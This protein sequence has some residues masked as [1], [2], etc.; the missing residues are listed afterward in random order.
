MANDSINIKATLDTSQVDSSLKGMMQEMKSLRAQLGSN[1]LSPEDQKNVLKRMGELRTSI[2]DL[3]KEVNRVGDASNVFG[4]ISTLIMPLAGAF[5]AIGSSLSIFGIE[6]EK[7]NEILQKT[8]Q[9]TI[10]LMA[11]QQVADA[12]KLKSLFLYRVEQ[13]KSFVLS[14]LVFKQTVQQTV[15]DTAGSKAKGLQAIWTGVATKAQWLW[16]AAITANPIGAIVVAIAA[17]VAGIILLVSWLNR[18]NKVIQQ[19]KTAID[20]TKF[21][22]D[23]LL[24]SYNKQAKALRDLDVE[25]KIIIG[26]LGETS[27]ALVRLDNEINDQINTI[28]NEYITKLNELVEKQTGFWN[29]IWV[30]IRG[31]FIGQGNSVLKEIE[32]YGDKASKLN[33]D[34]QNQ[35]NSIVEVGEKK[36]ANIVAKWEADQAKKVEEGNVKQLNYYNDFLRKKLEAFKENVKNIDAILGAA[37]TTKQELEFE[38]S[39]KGLSEAEQQIKR[40]EYEQSKF[41]QEIEKTNTGYLE[42]KKAAEENLK[43]AEEAFKMAEK[44]RESVYK[45]DYTE[46]L[47][48]I[49]IIVNEQEKLVRSK[50]KEIDRIMEAEFQGRKAQAAQY[51]PRIKKLNEDIIAAKKIITDATIQQSEYEN[52]ITE[53]IQKRADA[54]ATE[55]QLALELSNARKELKRVEETSVDSINEQID[56][57]QE[58]TDLQIKE[59][60]NQEDYNKKLKESNN[61]LTKQERELEILSIKANKLRNDNDKKRRLFNEKDLEEQKELEEERLNIQKGALIE[62]YK[63]RMEAAELAGDSGEIPLLKAQLEAGLTELEDAF[64]ERWKSIS[65]EIKEGIL[66]IGQA[67]IDT[68]GTIFANDMINKFNLLNEELDNSVRTASDSL[69]KLR[70]ADLI[71]EQEYNDKKAA[72]AEEEAIKS[73]K[74]RIDQAK[75]EKKLALIQ[76]ALNTA[77]AV[78]KSL[79]TM[80]VPLGIPSAIIAGAMGALQLALVA[81]Q[82]INFEKGGLI[83]GKRHMQ[84]GTVIEAE[85]GEFIVNR[86]AMA[87]PGAEVLLNN[88]NRSALASPPGTTNTT[89]TI[90]SDVIRQIVKEIASIPVINVET[91]YTKTQRKVASIESNSRW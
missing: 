11:L 64:V 10:G 46:Q 40:L 1:L 62:Y 91:D 67:L 29:T 87:Q 5:T 7:V 54:A 13:L 41:E 65:V 61:L 36:R 21:S 32:K 80:G 63:A 89:S 2:G 15:A 37:I 76:I 17:L 86:K 12:A 79:A 55:S 73:R 28:E 6:N 58:L 45:V 23:E 56:L 50:Q 38:I 19:Q 42:N 51:D 25:Y 33:E 85:E 47:K 74:L 27:A 39:I 78:A 24:E 34:K 84:G 68:I 3:R 26:T 44:Y 35:I 14:K 72:L 81:S 43:L 31:A 69:D 88:M 4:D 71:S 83:K 53:Q 8:S 30:G 18:S 75:A 9:L 22:S 48:S 20:G 49:G 77:M 57:K 82:P 90:D 16:N 52:K 70:D 66:E 59:I 60:E